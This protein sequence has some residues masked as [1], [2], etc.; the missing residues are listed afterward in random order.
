MPYVCEDKLILTPAGFSGASWELFAIASCTVNTHYCEQYLPVP[1]YHDYLK[2]LN[3]PPPDN[4]LA[5]NA[6][7]ANP[8]L[9]EQGCDPLNLIQVSW[10]ARTIPRLPLGSVA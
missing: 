8:Q 3:P 5:T 4:A 7:P 1:A 10:S 6:V 2:G 9:S